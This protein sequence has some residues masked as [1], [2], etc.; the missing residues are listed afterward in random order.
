MAVLLK[1]AK[2]PKPSNS[3]PI[4]QRGRVRATQPATNFGLRQRSS[5]TQKQPSKHSLTIYLS[6]TTMSATM[7]RRRAMHACCFLLPLQKSCAIMD[8]WRVVGCG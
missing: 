7:G 5:T 1:P 8:L 4:E 6:V 2:A 3:S